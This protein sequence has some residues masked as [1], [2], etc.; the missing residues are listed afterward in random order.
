MMLLSLFSI[1]FVCWF[2]FIAKI[3]E[4]SRTPKYILCVCAYVWWGHK[5]MYDFA[6][7]LDQSIFY[8]IH[9]FPIQIHCYCCCCCCFRCCVADNGTLTSKNTKRNSF[10]VLFV[11]KWREKKRAP[12][13]DFSFPSSASLVFLLWIHCRHYTCLASTHYAHAIV[14]KVNAIINDIEKQW[15]RGN[16]NL[17]NEKWRKNWVKCSISFLSLA[18]SCVST[19]RWCHIEVA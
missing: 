17:E 3:L 16:E 11:P 15:R 12:R 8:V 19:H 2:I 13:S 5:M 4:I 6:R 1:S 18:L 10:C 9:S 7:R 14:H